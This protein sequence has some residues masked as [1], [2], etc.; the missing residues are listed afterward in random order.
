MFLFNVPGRTFDRDA[1]AGFR[2]AA[3]VAP[4]GAAKATWAI[5][6]EKPIWIQKQHAR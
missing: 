1:S 6:N 3:F 4:G 5:N 2:D